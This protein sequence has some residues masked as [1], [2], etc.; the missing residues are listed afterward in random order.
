[1]IIKRKVQYHNHCFLT[2]ITKILTILGSVRFIFNS[3]AFFYGA[4]L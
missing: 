4:K 3:F 2:V 1:M